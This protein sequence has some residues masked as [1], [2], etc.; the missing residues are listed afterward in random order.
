V[1]SRPVTLSPLGLSSSHDI[2]NKFHNKTIL[3]VG[4]GGTNKVI[5]GLLRK[6]DPEK[7][8]NIQQDNACINFLELNKFG[9]PIRMKLNYIKHLN[10]K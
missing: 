7:F 8:Y 10:I 6:I 2:S 5:I 9:N 4:H 1:L 3:I